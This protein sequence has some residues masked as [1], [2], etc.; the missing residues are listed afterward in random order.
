MKLTK[1][2]L[3]LFLLASPAYANSLLY[4]DGNNDLAPIIILKETNSD[5][6]IECNGQDNCTTAVIPDYKKVFEASDCRTLI[7]ADYTDGTLCQDTRTNI[8]WVCN[9]SDSSNSCEDV[10]WS[11]LSAG[12]PGRDGA[13]TSSNSAFCF[14]ARETW[15]CDTNGLTCSDGP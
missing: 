15:T 8:F 11:M 2:L 6:K 12:Y 5:V 4:E 13:A 9:D 14:T 7:G 1:Y 10:E 3:S